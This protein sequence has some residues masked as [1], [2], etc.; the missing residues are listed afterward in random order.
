MKKTLAKII[1]K[2]NETPVAKA[3]FRAM[4]NHPLED[5]IH[6]YMML[7]KYA[8]KVFRGRWPD[9]EPIIIKNPILAYWYAK[10]VIGGP[11]PEAEKYIAKDSHAAW[12]YTRNVLKIYGSDRDEWI[13]SKL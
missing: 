6:Y 13:R 1:E 2:I 9:A 7:L 5:N 3:E 4:L 12:E 10:D 8:R 11:W